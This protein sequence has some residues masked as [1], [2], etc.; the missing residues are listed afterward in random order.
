MHQDHECPPSTDTQY[1]LAPDVSPAQLFEGGT[2]GS[3]AL[4]A[5]AR[6]SATG[7]SVCPVVAAAAPVAGAP[8]R[9]LRGLAAPWELTSCRISPPECRPKSWRLQNSRR[10]RPAGPWSSP[11]SRSLR[12]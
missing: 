12:Y 1:R 11:D 7:L 10:A 6:F 8:W 2:R 5:K 9:V 3:G 4:R